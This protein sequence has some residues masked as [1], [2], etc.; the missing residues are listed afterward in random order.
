[1]DE[2]CTR[3]LYFVNKRLQWRFI[4]WS[5]AVSSAGGILAVLLFSF[6]AYRKLD[7]LLYSMW[8]PADIFSGTIFLRAAL[9]ANGVG[10]IFVTIIC[11]AVVRIVFN[12]ISGPL[13]SI[14]HG[15]L[16]IGSG[17]LTSVI[18]LRQNDLFQEF[19]CEVNE[20]SAEFDRRFSAIKDR[21]KQIEEIAADLRAS[22]VPDSKIDALVQQ[23]S[24]LQQDVGAFRK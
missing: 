22:G 16:R 14:K 24:G 5:L 7:S 13:Q 10:V 23:I 1:M 20:L 11:I 12:K 19:A 17:N 4:I 9:L 8:I 2:R 3:K 18:T 15:I 21:A 6:L